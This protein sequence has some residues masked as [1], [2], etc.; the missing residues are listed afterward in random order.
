[1]A[2]GPQFDDASVERISQATRRVERMPIQRGG[3]INSA[4]RDNDEPWLWVSISANDIDAELVGDDE[5]NY[6][7]AQLI[8]DGA[9]GLTTSGLTSGDGDETFNARE[10]N[11]ILVHTGYRTRIYSVGY[12]SEGNQRWMF[13]AG[14]NSEWQGKTSESI[15]ASSSGTV[16]LYINGVDINIDVEAHLIEPHG[17]EGIDDAT[18]VRVQYNHTSKHWEIVAADCA[19]PEEEE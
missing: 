12:D 6:S 13:H 17:S 1:M 8:P 3:A 18:W 16:R 11:N 14:E 9:G 5:I 4:S 10:A 7:W 15:S 2:F 19:E